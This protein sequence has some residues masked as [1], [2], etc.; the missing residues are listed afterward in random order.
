MRKNLDKK[1]SLKSFN[2]Q[3]KKLQKLNDKNTN[4]SEE[5][6]SERKVKIYSPVLTNRNESTKESNMD[7]NIVQNESVRCS[8]SR[9]KLK[10]LFNFS[11]EA[12][13][14]AALHLLSLK[15][16]IEIKSSKFDSTTKKIFTPP[17]IETQ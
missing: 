2:K 7:D 11:S 14:D 10:R 15:K 6:Q 1:S 16:T 5:V 3:H 9:S 8:I 13:A 12:D 4:F 17:A